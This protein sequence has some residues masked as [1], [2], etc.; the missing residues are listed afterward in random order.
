[1]STVQV[2]LHDPSHAIRS[3]PGGLERLGLPLEPADRSEQRLVHLRALS[4][5]KKRRRPLPPW[6]LLREIGRADATEIPA[7]ELL[8][9]TP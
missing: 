8:P 3:V 6:V 4:V 1:M 2:L 5:D 7:Q 9:D